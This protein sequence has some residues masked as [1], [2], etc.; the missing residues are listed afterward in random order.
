MKMKYIYEYTGSMSCSYH[1]E[2]HGVNLVL[3]RIIAD[4]INQKPFFADGPAYLF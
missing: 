1:F 4:A 2:E 3:N